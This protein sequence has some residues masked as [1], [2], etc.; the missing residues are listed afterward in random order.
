MKINKKLADGI[1]ISNGDLEMVIAVRKPNANTKITHALYFKGVAADFRRKMLI[2]REELKEVVDKLDDKEIN[3][4]LDEYYKKEM[5][6]INP[7]SQQNF[8]TIQLDKEKCTPSSV[9]SSGVD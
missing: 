6:R 8:F 1:K 7:N 3:Q 4:I 5:K 2:P 9:P